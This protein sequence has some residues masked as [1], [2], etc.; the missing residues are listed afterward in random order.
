V[1]EGAKQIGTPAGQPPI[2]KLR[3][4]HFAIENPT[5]GDPALKHRSQAF[6]NAQR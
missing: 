4:P 1:A 3:E 2:Q 6:Q 5:G